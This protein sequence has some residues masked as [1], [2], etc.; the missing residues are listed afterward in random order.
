MIQEE[1]NGSIVFIYLFIY[2]GCVVS[3]L[4]CTGFLF[5]CGKRGLLFVAVRELLLLQS[6]GSRH[7]GFSSCGTRAQ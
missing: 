1:K 3:S 5:S 6:T 4:L 2:L 7:V